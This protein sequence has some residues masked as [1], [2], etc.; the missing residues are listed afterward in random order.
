MILYDTEVILNEKK[1]IYISFFYFLK[2]DFVLRTVFSA[3]F[4]FDKL[5]LVKSLSATM[6]SRL[7]KRSTNKFQH[8]KVERIDSIQIA[9]FVK[10]WCLRICAQARNSIE[11]RSA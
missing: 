3:S 10:I 8:S 7:Q 11:M 4:R 1:Y 9:S 5:T 2:K 6:S